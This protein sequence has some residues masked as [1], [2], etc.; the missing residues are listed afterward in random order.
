MEDKNTIHT[1][2]AQEYWLSKWKKLELGLEGQKA[3]AMVEE[4]EIAMAGK[5]K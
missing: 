3:F 1:E 4:G 5:A 2:G